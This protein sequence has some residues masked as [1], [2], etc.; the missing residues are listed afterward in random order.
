M[1]S[2]HKG[3]N[4][5]ATLLSQWN[6]STSLHSL[7]NPLTPFFSVHLLIKQISAG[8]Y[9]CA[10]VTREGELYTWGSNRYNCLGRFDRTILHLLSLTVTEKFKKRTLSTQLLLVTWEAT[11]R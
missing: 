7:P 6:T 8:D 9:H 2:W 11:A 1:D 10:A 3:R 5:C 4:K